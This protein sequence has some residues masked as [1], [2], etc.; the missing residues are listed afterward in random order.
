MTND[1]CRIF[2]EDQTIFCKNS[3]SF[4]YSRSVDFGED[5]LRERGSSVS[6]THLVIFS[7]ANDNSR[8]F[9]HYQIMFCMQLWIVEISRHIVFGE[10]RLREKGSLPTTFFVL[11]MVFSMAKDKAN[12]S[13]IKILLHTALNCRV[14]NTF[15]FW[16][17]SVK[18]KG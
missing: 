17:R 9:K 1:N 6:Y 10:D 8:K 12:W 11:K 16:W 7:M 3:L 4:M 5:R 14:L 2:K 18:G 15:C 13:R